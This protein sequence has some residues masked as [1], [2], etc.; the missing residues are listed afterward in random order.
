MEKKSVILVTG[1]TGMV[2]TVL[3]AKL[4]QLSFERILSPSRNDLDLCNG[5]QVDSFFDR[6]RPEYVFM[7]AAKVGGIAANQADPVGFLEENVKIQI[8]LFD[9]CH[10]YRTKKNLFLGSSCIFPREC[11]QPMK[12]EYLLTGPL[13]PTNEG[14]AL[15]KIMGLKLA[16]Y[17]YRQ[18]GMKT[19]CPMPC[20]IYGTNDHFDFHRSHV[21]SALV[22]RFVDAQDDGAMRVTLWGTGVARR[23]FI[24]VQ[25]VADALLFFMDRCDRPEIINVGTGEDLTIRDLANLIA[26]R[27]GYRGEIMWDPT[28]PDGMPRK[29]LDVSKQTDM[30]F[31]PMI[32]LEEGVGKT[33]EE[34]RRRK[35]DGSIG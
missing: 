20:N 4:Q 18:V 19:I 33:I 6:H 7:L 16:E 10:K 15:S 3:V 34:Y 12:E 11:P 9:A 8:H 28:K 27:V 29:C 14:Y 35:K 24:H 23:E 21:L 17:Y 32:G 25:D 22:R 30:G 1:S 2:G 31:R 13:E 26:R 5:K